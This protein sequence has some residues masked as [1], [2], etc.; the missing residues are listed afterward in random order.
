MRP[1]HG[2]SNGSET[3]LRIQFLAGSTIDTLDSARPPRGSLGASPGVYT[4]HPCALRRALSLSDWGT[5]R[6]AAKPNVR[7]MTVRMEP[8]IRNGIHRLF[9]AQVTR[10]PEA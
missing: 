2:R 4:R 8:P 1:T 7:V 10:N 9:E 3:L 6:D 5:A